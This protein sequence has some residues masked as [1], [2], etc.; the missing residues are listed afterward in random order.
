[1]EVLK[2]TQTPLRI[3][4]DCTGLNNAAD[5]L[6]AVDADVDDVLECKAEVV[7]HL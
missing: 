1:M 2:A 7:R 5:R 6:R 4:I 3:H